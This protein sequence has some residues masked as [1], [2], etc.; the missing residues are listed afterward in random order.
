MKDRDT[1]VDT[2]SDVSAVEAADAFASLGSETRLMILK[3][4]VRAGPDGLPVG[5]LQE[6]I[7][8]AASTLSHHLR[9]MVRA[10]V[11]EQR[12]VG[13][14][15]ICH[16]RYDRIAALAGFLLSEC[17]ADTCESDTASPEK[18]KETTA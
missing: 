11:L 10:G 2:V 18:Q 15:L 8:A 13:R 16:A 6:S 7:G 3:A 1:P 5:A 12:R 14:T 4:L 17:C 9:A